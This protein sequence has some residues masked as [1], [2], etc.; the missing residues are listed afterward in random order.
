MVH[1]NRV[2]KRDAAEAAA[3]AP[4]SAAD[5]RREAA[6]AA[7]RDAAIASSPKAAVGPSLSTLSSR[8][9]LRPP[10]RGPH[11]SGAALHGRALSCCASGC[12]LCVRSCCGGGRVSSFW[13]G[14]HGP[15]GDRVLM[16]L[17]VRRGPRRCMRCANSPPTSSRGAS[18]RPRRDARGASWTS[19]CGRPRGATTPMSSARVPPSVPP[20][21]PPTLP[22]PLSGA[23][24]L[25]PDA[26][27]HKR[28]APRELKVQ[29][30]VP[31]STLPPYVSC[32]NARSRVRGHEAHDRTGG[33][34]RPTDR[35]P[36]ADSGRRLMAAS[37]WPPSADRLHL[38]AYNWPP[39]TGRFLL[40]ANDRT[41]TSRLL[42]AVYSCP[43]S[44]SR[45]HYY[46]PPPGRP[47]L[48]ASNR[49][50]LATCDWPLAAGYYTPSTGYLL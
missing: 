39:A 10:K 11:P 34:T 41:P 28:D 7:M 36:T 24:S 12:A 43:R 44:T 40:A 1:L 50:R 45:A 22:L 42:L 15:W 29:A 38:A 33:R 4:R 2:A 35:L 30:R 25:V 48:T 19:S 9:R 17:D 13:A 20:S 21:L 3:D 16:R 32:R 14:R 47:L 26:G 31:R 18:K 27:R 37:Y 6:V 46:P 49:L 8:R 23:R 5:A